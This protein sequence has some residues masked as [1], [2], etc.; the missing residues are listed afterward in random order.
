MDSLLLILSKRRY[1]APALVFMSINVLLGTW[2]IYI[3]TIKYKLGID[4]ADLGIA[5]FFMALG[6]LTMLLIAPLIINKIGVGKATALGIFIFLFTLIIPFI[7]NSLFVLCFGMYL[8]GATSGFTDIAMNTL[9]T[10]IEDEDG[11]SIM[12]ANHGFF[13]I[14]GFFGAG[15]GGLFLELVNSSLLY[16]L[17]V[18]TIMVLLNMNFVSAYYNIKTHQ[19]EEKRSFNWNYFLPLLTLGLIGFFVMACE[20][21]IVDWSALYLETVSLA[22]ISLIGLGYTA[23]SIT[24]ALGRFLGDTISALY[25]SKQLLLLGCVI[26]LIGFGSILFVKPILAIIGFGLVGLGLSVVVPELF[27]I[28]GRVNNIETSQGISFIAGSGFFGFLI[29]PVVLGF[30]ADF[31]SLKL[32]FIALFCFVLISLL[33]SLGLKK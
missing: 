32:S 13:S 27:R 30:L 6:T 14:G 1:F 21:A 17:I 2:A 5:I 12:S 33:L 19:A 25:G 9:V 31:S 3:P 28:A 15:I 20:G 16:L 18:I 8:F 4:E 7:A 22:S 23:F 29:G 10:Q 26:A 11:I 24:M